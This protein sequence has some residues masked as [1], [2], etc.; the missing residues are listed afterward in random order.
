MP[1]TI[2]AYFNW[3]TGVLGASWAAVVL[4]YPTLAGTIPAELYGAGA[5]LVAV[6]NGALLYAKGHPLPTAQTTVTTTVT[7][8]EPPAAAVPTSI[9]SSGADAV[10]GSI[11]QPK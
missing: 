6:I 11:V 10:T 5:V 7:T 4:I 2:I 8:T 3:I 9:V 1:K